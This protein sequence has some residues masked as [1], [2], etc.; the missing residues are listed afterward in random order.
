MTDPVIG[1]LTNSPA[2]RARADA[3]DGLLGETLRFDG[4]M[5]E[6]LPKAW[7]SCDLIVSHLALGATMRLVAPLL[8]DKKTDPGVVV[9]D[10]AGR[11]CI[12]LVGGHAGGANDL[13]P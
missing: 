4:P 2:S 11:F 1:Q 5:H 8:A 12:P 13:A 6:S 9:V 3:I 7:A 10:E